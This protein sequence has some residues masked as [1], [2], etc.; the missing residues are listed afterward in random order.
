[1]NNSNLFNKARQLIG[2]EASL[3]SNLSALEADV[4]DKIR[5]CGIAPPSNIHFDGKFHRFSSNGKSNDKAGWYLLFDDGYQAGA[6]GCFRNN[7]NE[8][9]CP[10]KSQLSEPE[11]RRVRNAMTEACRIRNREIADAQHRAR[12]QAGSI[13]ENA[14]PAPENF[15][16]LHK[17]SIRP[18]GARIGPNGELVIPVSDES[19]ILSLQFIHADGAKRFLPGGKI[20]GGFYIV[21]D[22]IGSK[23]ICV[24]EGFATGASIFEA[25]EIPT[26][27]AF[28]A[29]NLTTV[30]GL[31]RSN[32]PEAT[33][34]IC[35]D[36]DYKTD[37]NPGIQNAREA[38]HR[39]NGRLIL[40]VF[41]EHRGEK[42]TDFN[43][44]VM[45]FGLQAV[46][47]HILSSKPTAKT[48]KTEV[49]AVLAVE[50]E[51]HRPTESTMNTGI[52]STTPSNWP[53]IKPIVLELPDV[54][55]FDASAM[56]PSPLAEY[57]DDVADRMPSPPDFV[58]S[59]LLVALGTTIG[60]RCGVQP[61]A[62]DDW[63][64]IPNLWGG[65]VGSPSSKKSPA[66]AKGIAPLEQ[67]ADEAKAN[68]EDRK[69]SFEADLALHQ[70]EIEHLES[71]L[72]KAAKDKTN[73]KSHVAE[74]SKELRHL[75]KLRPT[76]PTL[77]RFKSNDTTTEKLGEI[78]VDNPAG[79]L[80]MRD[81]LVGLIS[82]WEK[83][84]REGDR[85][86]YLEAW[87][88]NSRFETDRI[89][90]GS[91]SIPN[92]CVSVFGGIQPDRL[93]EY[94]VQAAHNAGNDGM[95][96]RLQMLVF[97]D[98]RQWEW[99][100]LPPNKEARV[101]VF[102]VFQGISL[103]EPTE[104]GAFPVSEDSKFPYFK[105]DEKAQEIF[106]EWSTELHTVRVPNEPLPL[107]QQHLAKYDKLFPALALIFHMVESVTGRTGNQIGVES[108]LRATFWCE[109]LEAHAR[110][111]YSLVFDNG[112]T[113]AKNLSEHIANG[114]LKDGFTAREVRRH[115]WSGLTS[116]EAVKSALSHLCELGWLRADE[117]VAGSTGG[118]TTTRFK[119]NPKAACFG[120][121]NA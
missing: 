121:S 97:P 89:G 70:A 84:G 46:R 61:K 68:F 1:M 107:I 51:D 7:I 42:D 77:R 62:H 3:S 44:M 52:E 104:F 56:L 111:C 92:L 20:K 101:K 64:V 109:Y 81:E 31:F 120:E 38:A 17:K 117:P 37:G 99:R 27:V 80:V 113:P 98:H 43:D 94:L 35:G 23:Q 5:S 39:N 78:L 54:P 15:G 2:M 72:K 69:N 26:V 30:A 103:G 102:E 34:L 110:R 100:D 63:T 112:R 67:L 108:A 60:A 118:R 65:I 28:N 53:D 16:Y 19:G 29:G 57:V 33:L 36:D 66:I 90:R 119:I 87:N 116:D 58:A 24:C 114:K 22:V 86:F 25:T 21:G 96:Q 47:N 73:G 55:K 49:S 8:N 6:F 105:F 9:W 88:G 45:A 82:T 71:E 50:P 85:A 115:Q 18:C 12:L 48:D 41:D 32:H 76:E 59:A 106:I 13:W 75:R 93:C 4:I 95:L 10:N 83:D 91:I 11:L 79:L 14:K 74:I 40:P